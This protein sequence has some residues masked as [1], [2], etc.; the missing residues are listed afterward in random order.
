MLMDDNRCT[1]QMMQK[2]LIVS[3]AAIHRIILEELHMKKVVCRWVLRNLIEHQKE[4]RVRIGKETLKLLNEGGSRIISKIVTDDER[5]IPFFDVPT[6]QESK[7]WIFEDDALP[8]KVK[9]QRAMK[10]LMHTI[11][12]INTRLVKAIKLEG[13]KTVTT[14][15]Y[16]TKCLPEILQEVNA[17]GLMLHHDNATSHT[18]EL[19]VEFLKQKQIKEIEHPPYS[20]DLAMCDSFDHFLI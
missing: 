19:I 14:N 2:E 20:S 6:C 15:R 1:Y 17:R 18:A 3:S 13:Q 5:Y 10:K 7:V 16:T 12:F 4:E 11:F 8:T 9:R